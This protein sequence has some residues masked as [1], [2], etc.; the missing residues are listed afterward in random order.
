MR[1]LPRATL[2]TLTP[3]FVISEK[4]AFFARNA[5]IQ[6]DKVLI[7]R[8]VTMNHGN[9]YNRT[10]GSF[11]APL[12][13]VYVFHLFYTPPGD[14]LEVEIQVN[15]DTACTGTSTDDQYEYHDS[16]GQGTCSA[17]VRL[18]QGDVV[19]VRADNT[20]A[21]KEGAYSG[22]LGFLYSAV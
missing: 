13:G 1:R 14:R 10:T 11:T 22:F 17:I 2:P 3:P 19:T 7:F 20:G 18:N 4:V 8:D 6:T 16:L 15:G 9:A 12:G 5:E 21:I